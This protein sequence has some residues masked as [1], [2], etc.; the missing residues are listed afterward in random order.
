M[1]MRGRRKL[2]WAVLWAAGSAPLN[3]YSLLCR[4]LKPSFWEEGNLFLLQGKQA[5]QTVLMGPYS[6]SPWHYIAI[7]PTKITQGKLLAHA[8][9]EAKEQLVLKSFFNISRQ[10]PGKPEKH[11]DAGNVTSVT[12][13]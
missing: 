4:A 10:E 1:Q 6:N 3:P 7:Q 11:Y 9:A 8:A 12:G 2:A 5:F 13:W